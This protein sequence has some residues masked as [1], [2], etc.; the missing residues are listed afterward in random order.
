MRVFLSSLVF[1]TEANFADADSHRLFVAQ[2]ALPSARR[3]MLRSPVQL[4]TASVSRPETVIP[5]EEE[6]STPIVVD[7]TARVAVPQ[8]TPPPQKG[9][10]RIAFATATF[11]ATSAWFGSVTGSVFFGAALAGATAASVAYLLAR[12]PKRPQYLA[13]PPMAKGPAENDLGV[14]LVPLYELHP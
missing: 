6:I 2:T 9:K 13:G 11:T 12:R 14:H 3:P 1:L 5:D 10:K 7:P 8:W 4:M